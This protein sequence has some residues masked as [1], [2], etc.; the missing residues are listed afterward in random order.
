MESLEGR[1]ATTAIVMPNSGSKVPR[2]FVGRGNDADAVIAGVSGAGKERLVQRGVTPRP[3]P[4]PPCLSLPRRQYKQYADRCIK[5][6]RRESF[7]RQF[8]LS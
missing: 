6:L 5:S 4:A 1:N 3:R 7:A 2:Q 8:S